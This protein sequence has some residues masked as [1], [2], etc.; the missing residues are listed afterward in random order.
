MQTRFADPEY[1]ARNQRTRRGI[2][3][4]ERERLVLWVALER[5]NRPLHTA[6]MYST[7]CRDQECPQ[8]NTAQHHCLA[9]YAVVIK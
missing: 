1:A 9:R 5:A 8:H 2:F 4:D 3:L 6:L 7:F